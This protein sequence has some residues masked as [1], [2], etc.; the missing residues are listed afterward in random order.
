MKNE[1]KFP[2]KEFRVRNGKARTSILNSNSMH[3][4][5]V[6]FRQLRKILSMD[7]ETFAGESE[8]RIYAR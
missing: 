8:S 7:E 4:F 2:N 1:R 3:G 6:L 5:S